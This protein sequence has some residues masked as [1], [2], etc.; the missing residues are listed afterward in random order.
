MG[1]L[2]GDGYRLTKPS[3]RAEQFTEKCIKTAKSSNCALVRT[4]DLFL[5]AKHVKE[6]HD[7]SFA[8]LCRDAIKNGIGKIVDRHG[9]P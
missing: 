9:D 8:K 1:I 6:C 4:S 5:V 7:D 3:E 2:F